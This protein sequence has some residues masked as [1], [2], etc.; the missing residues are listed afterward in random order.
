MNSFIDVQVT[1][2]WKLSHLI[3]YAITQFL[4]FQIILLEITLIYNVYRTLISNNRGVYIFYGPI[5]TT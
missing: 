4:V 1:T 5:L 3:K 2:H